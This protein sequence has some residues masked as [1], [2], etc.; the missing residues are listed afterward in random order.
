VFVLEG[1]EDGVLDDVGVAVDVDVLDS[2]G[3]MVAEG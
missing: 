3:V 2:D 1:V